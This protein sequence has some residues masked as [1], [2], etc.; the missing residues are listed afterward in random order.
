MS[1]EFNVQSLNSN[2]SEQFESPQNSSLEILTNQLKIL[3]QEFSALKLISSKNAAEVVELQ[4]YVNRM[5][6]TL[7]ILSIILPIKILIIAIQSCRLAKYV[8]QKKPIRKKLSK[9]QLSRK[10]SKANQLDD[11]ESGI[12]INLRENI[13]RN[14]NVEKNESESD[15]EYYESSTLTPEI[16]RNF[17]DEFQKVL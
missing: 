14:E 10:N 16:M 13:Q 15:E 7:L 5:R 17:T 3:E 9:L 8:H 1:F 4:T 11:V 2:T 12:V 6:V